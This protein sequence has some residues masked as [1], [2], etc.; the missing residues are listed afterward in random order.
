MI[1][2]MWASREGKDQRAATLCIMERSVYKVHSPHKL[3]ASHRSIKDTA[4]MRCQRCLTQV[5]RVLRSSAWSEEKYL[6][7]SP[8]VVTAQAVEDRVGGEVIRG[9]FRA[10]CDQTV[11]NPWEWTGEGN[12]RALEI[13]PRKR[14]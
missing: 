5:C 1:R 4:D 8:S 3:R 6:C 10:I 7:G 12:V 9:G 2:V 13:F 14:N 11:R